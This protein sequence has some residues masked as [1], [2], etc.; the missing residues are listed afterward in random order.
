VD[1]SRATRD[2]WWTASIVLACAI[3]C[4]GCGRYRFDVLATSDSRSDD[5]STTDTPPAAAAFDV[6]SIGTG[7]NTTSF[8]WTHVITGS[9]PVLFVYVA[10]RAASGAPTVTGITANGTALAPVA[11]LCPGC[12]VG[13]LDNFELWY[14]ATPPTG[15]VAISVMLAG[16]AEGAT[17]VSSSYT[18][19][20]SPTIDVPVTNSATSTTPS[21]SWN[22]TNAARWAVAGV[23]DQGGSVISLVPSAGEMMR[24][25]SVCDANTFVAQSVA[26]QVALSSSTVVFSWTFDY[27]TYGSGY[28]CKVDNTAH[29]WIALGVTLK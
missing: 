14:L 11:R 17:G 23:M 4:A 24:T 18:G 8:A 20:T 15:S 21:L 13:G 12:S 6:A 27:G 22:G 7:S 29:A 10:T 19:V 28:Y 2:F 16:S 5:G 1:L 26:D 25:D 9:S 3:A